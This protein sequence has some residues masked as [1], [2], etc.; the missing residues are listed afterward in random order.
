MLLNILSCT[1]RDL[2]MRFDSNIIVLI[3]QHGYGKFNLKISSVQI[4]FLPL[5]DMD[6][7]SDLL[8]DTHDSVIE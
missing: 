6:V 2:K 1:L 5:P 7:Y 4:M 3:N 8:A